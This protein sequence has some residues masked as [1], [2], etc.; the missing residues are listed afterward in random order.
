MLSDYR[1]TLFDPIVGKNIRLVRA[2]PQ[3][4]STFFQTCF[5][6]TEF[7]ALY[8][9][10]ANT[11]QAVTIALKRLGLLYKHSFNKSRSIQWVI[12][13]ETHVGSIPIGIASID[14][15]RSDHNRSQIAI[16]VLD[17]H[18]R[19]GF[20]SIAAILL[21]YDFAFNHLNLHK[22]MGYVYGHNEYAQQVFTKTGLVREAVFREQILTKQGYIDLFASAMLQSEFRVNSQLSRLSKRLLGRDIVSVS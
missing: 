20:D 6:D 15:Y 1:N 11:D 3:K 8:D 16:G 5:S 12:I 21:I 10:A 7:L 19:N 9:P 22:I 2:T 18:Y 4:H 13:K 14:D 17:K